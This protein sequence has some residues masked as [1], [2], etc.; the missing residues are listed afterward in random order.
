MK[1]NHTHGIVLLFIQTI[2]EEVTWVVGPDMNVSNKII[3]CFL[4]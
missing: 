2:M 1:C 4:S 3:G